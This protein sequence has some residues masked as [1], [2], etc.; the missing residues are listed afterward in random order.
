MALCYTMQQKGFTMMRGMGRWLGAALTLGVLYTATAYADAFRL[1]LEDVGTGTGVV[2]TDNGVGDV[3]PLAGVMTYAGA[4]TNDFLINVTTGLSKPVIGG[5]HNDAELDLNSVNVQVGHAG[6]LRITLEDVGYS[7]GTDGALSAVGAVGGT[8]SAAAGSI[9]AFQSWVNASNLVPDLGLNASFPSVLPPLGANP[10]DSGAMWS[11]E[12]VTFGLGAFSSTASADFIP[13]GPYA[14]FTQA[15]INF[16]GAGMVSFDA[17]LSTVSTV[18][19]PTSLLLVGS[20]LAGIGLWGYGK[21]KA[22]Q[23]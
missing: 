10:A 22:A 1:R 5:V 18:P 9:A 11:G 2:V 3:N 23:A 6:T 13:S 19:E 16:T 17:N 15:T 21:K 4:I 7:V 8:L 14:L 12:G 20:G